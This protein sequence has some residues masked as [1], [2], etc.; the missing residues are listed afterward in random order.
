[1]QT[2]LL[3]RE[4]MLENLKF[5]NMIC[6][7]HTKNGNSLTPSHIEL[8]ISNANQELQKI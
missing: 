3:D 7:E 1:M 2:P 8:F 4:D 5:A 6:W